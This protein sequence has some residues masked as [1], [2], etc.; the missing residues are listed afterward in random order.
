M[1]SVRSVRGQMIEVR[2]KKSE[3]RS[4]KQVVKIR[5]FLASC[6]LL[7]ASGSAYAAF[8]KSDAGTSAVHFL[9]LGA[10]ARSSGMGDI[11]VGVSE[12]A[13]NI[14]WNAAGLA[15]I[16]KTS[17]SVM[18]AVWFEDIGYTWIGY[19]QPT[20]TGGL[21]IGIQY[22]SYG[23]IEGNDTS[24]VLTSNYSPSDM[25]ITLGYGNDVSD[26]VSLGAGIKY[27]SSKIKD[28]GVA[29]AGDIGMLYKPA[30][31]KTSLGISLQ[32]LGGK[33][34]Y[35]ES[36][37]NLPMTIRVGGGYNIQPEWLVGLEMTA[38]NDSEL[39]IGA[40][41]EYKYAASEG[42]TLIGRAGYNTKTKDIGGLKGLSLGAGIELKSCGVDYA[43][44][45]FGD[46]GDTHR[47]S[48][49]LKF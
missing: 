40:G 7:L 41:T 44:V 31:G 3:A 11:G 2:S 35:I 24:G 9:K 22:L 28:T 17:I 39:G 5:L 19:G 12:G 45:P 30:E 21:G 36:G 49:N 43:F 10:G 14:Y 23:S 20:E 18:H 27:I 8:S 4:Q 15:G 13:S 37:D 46:L 25:S 6:L 32:N 16:E 34:K 48:L 47:V 26:E 38:V 42:A 29:I 33:M 1:K